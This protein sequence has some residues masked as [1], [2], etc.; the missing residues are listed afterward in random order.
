MHYPVHVFE[1]HYR[2]SGRKQTIDNVINKAEKIARREGIRQV[3]SLRH[4]IA[5]H[6]RDSRYIIP[7]T[8]VRRYLTDT[9]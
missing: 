2:A 1:E 3:S 7:A 8:T 4:I 6:A 9:S 5:T